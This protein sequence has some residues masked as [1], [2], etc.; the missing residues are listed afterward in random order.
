[1]VGTR[2][3]ATRQ[4]DIDRPAAARIFDAFLGGSHSFA[5]ERELVE[6][7]EQALPGIHQCY[8]ENRA[9][10]RRAVEFLLARGVRQFLDLGSG[11]PTIGHIHEVAQRRV[12]DFRVVYVDNEPLTVAHSR[13]LLTADPR[14]EIIQADCRE[15]RSVLTAPEV[16]ALLDFRRP[17]GLVMSAVLH[18]VPDEDAPQ[19]L[20]EQYRNALGPGS[21]LV[22]SHL[23][24]D[25]APRAAQ[26]LTELYD[27]TAD[28]LFIRE[29]GWIKRLFGDFELVTP[30]ATYLSGWRPESPTD[31]PYPLIYGGV[32]RKP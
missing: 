4:V 27:E 15:P 7:A 1:M 21:F 32:A 18:H 24:Y 22:I 19:E 25:R 12:D 28:P 11:I 8:R 10:L 16:S 29:T 20:V 2:E 13:P 23:A 17:V 14:A 31:A 3:P 9:F 6:R 26:I 30:G 5:V